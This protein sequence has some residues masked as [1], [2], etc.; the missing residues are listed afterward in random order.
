MP[1]ISK[2]VSENE[3]LASGYRIKLS[4]EFDDGTVKEIK[5]RGI[6]QVSA[7]QYLISKEPQVLESKKQQDLDKQIQNDSDIPTN[8]T[9]QIEIYKAW[10]FKGYI[11]DDPLEAYKYLSKVAQ[12]VIDLGLTVQQLAAAF[13][14]S[15]ETINLVLDKW[16]YLKSN[17]S[18]LLAYVAVKDGM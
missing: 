9:A 10:M 11:S 15:V 5:C 6:N 1:I 2:S 8:D 13:N 3:K 16:Q 17:K 7:N 4:Y 18:T 14:E 12:K